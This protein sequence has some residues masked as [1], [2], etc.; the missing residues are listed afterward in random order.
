VQGRKNL[1]VKLLLAEYA[2]VEAGKV[3]ILG[4]GWRTTPADIPVHMSICGAIEIGWDETN[5]AHRLQITLVDEDGQRVTFEGNAQPF[6]IS[7]NFEVGRPV[8]IKRGS[9]INAPVAI[10][11]MRPPLPAGA[12]AFNVFLGGEEM[13]RLPFDVVPTMRRS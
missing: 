2:S 4:G 12:Y 13:A 5:E 8:G 1:E 3:N 7:A 10:N 6:E 9:S 11:F